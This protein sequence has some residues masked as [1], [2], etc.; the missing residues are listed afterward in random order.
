VV[1]PP[2]RQAVPRHD[3][4]QVVDI[5]AAVPGGPVVSRRPPVEVVGPLAR[6]FEVVD[7]VAESGQAEGVLEVIPGH[8][9][10][11]RVLGDQARDND[12]KLRVH[13]WLLMLCF[14]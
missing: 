12:A 9:P 2:V 7:V 4:R 10:E 11:Q 1:G 6:V 3:P 14:I 8:S 5:R 13:S